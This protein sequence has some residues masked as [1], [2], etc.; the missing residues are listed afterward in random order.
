MGYLLIDD[1]AS[2]GKLR[3]YDTL[4][5]GHCQGVIDKKRWRLEGGIYKCSGC[6]K[7]LCHNCTNIHS[8]ANLEL[9]CDPWQEKVE[10][11]VKA[12]DDI[13]K[14]LIV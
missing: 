11:A 4:G 1:R 3:E 8:V 10:R 7:A 14:G 9:K 5:C 6:K 2:G 12:W 13:K